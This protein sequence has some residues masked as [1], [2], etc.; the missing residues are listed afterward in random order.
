MVCAAAESGVGVPGGGDRHAVISASP[1]HRDLTEPATSAEFSTDMQH[2]LH[3]G[4]H[5]IGA[6]RVNELDDG[7]TDTAA[8]P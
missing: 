1:H 6:Q 2:Q 3:G 4:G 5:D 7:H 8:K